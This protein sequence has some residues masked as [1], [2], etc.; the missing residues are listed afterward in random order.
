MFVALENPAARWRRGDMIPGSE[1]HASRIL[2]LRS[3]ELC[4]KLDSGHT[5]ELPVGTPLPTV[6]RLQYS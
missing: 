6:S 1:R 2:G 4:L 5:F 3:R